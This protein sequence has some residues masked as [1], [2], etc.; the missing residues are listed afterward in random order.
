MENIVSEANLK[1]GNFPGGNMSV[2]ENVLE[3]IKN[4]DDMY[5]TF[6][7]Q[8]FVSKVK[9]LAEQYPDKVTILAENKDGSIYA[10]LPVRA[11]HLSLASREF[12]E[13]QRIAA[14]ER[15]KRARMDRVGSSNSDF[16]L[17]DDLLEDEDLDD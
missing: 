15:L 4:S 1:K 14:A 16:D 5:V 3:F 7:Q 8:R 11:L 12:T 17:D 10:K 6:S 2:I 13:E 9:K